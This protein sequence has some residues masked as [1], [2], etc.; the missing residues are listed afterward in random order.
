[1]P[2]CGPESVQCWNPWSSS[3]QVMASY[4]NSFQECAAVLYL[5]PSIHM[6][7]CAR[8]SPVLE[9]LGQFWSNFGKLCHHHR[10]VLTV[11]YL[12]PSHQCL[13]QVGDVGSFE[14]NHLVPRDAPLSRCHPK[15]ISRW[16]QC[17]RCNGRPLR[18]KWTP[19]NKVFL[20]L[21]FS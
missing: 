19:S 16:K 7:W 2:W 17:T 10:D 4:G 14:V 13:N 6:P 18:S 21:S 5:H 15:K 9:A 12:H 8:T 11:T 20:K 1:M 3:G